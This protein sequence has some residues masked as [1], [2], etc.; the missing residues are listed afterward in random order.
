LIVTDP[1]IDRLA[2][3]L[4]RYSTKVNPGDLVG[5]T[6]FPFSP[7]GL[8]LMEAVFREVLRAGGNP[9][10]YLENRFTEG[11]DRILYQEGGDAQLVYQEPWAEQ[12]TRFLDCDIK[13]MAATNTR[14]LSGVDSS[15]I[16]LHRRS[17]A[18]LFTLYLRRGAEGSLRWVISLT[19]TPA[20]AQD[21]EMSLSAFSEFV[22]ASTCADRDDPISFWKQLSETQA[23]LVEKLANK[24]AVSVQSP[25]IDLTFSIEG[26]IFVNCDGE[27]NMPDGELF[28]CPV[29]DTV[30]GWMESSFPAI[31]RGVDVGRVRLRFEH[32]RVV[33]AEAEKNQDYLSAML[34]TDDGARRV[35]EFGIGTN[36]QIKTFTKVMLFDEKIGGT[37]HL[38][39]GASF[40]ETGGVNKSAIH[41]DLLCDMREGGNITIDG[42]RVYES[43]RFV[44]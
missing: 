30:E 43:G 6:G 1:R 19:P 5:I 8:P 25:H 15:R 44:I 20:Y 13:I 16:A 28:T 23:V 4:V 7:E 29:E 21:A 22:Y 42:K 26:R 2:E 14:G 36:T 18:E 12:R 35:G 9:F 10:P 31:H 32:G 34:D 17:R 41:W 39:L 40:P 24:R 27:R 37:I 11:F 38:A 33:E 3:I